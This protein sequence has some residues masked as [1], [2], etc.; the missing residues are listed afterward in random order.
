MEIGGEAP[1]L[2]ARRKRHPHHQPFRP[3]FGIAASVLNVANMIALRLHESS[4]AL[5]LRSIGQT[6]LRVGRL[7]IDTVQA[8]VENY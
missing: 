4:G 2:S 3:E 6:W 8:L 7:P 1:R 5:S